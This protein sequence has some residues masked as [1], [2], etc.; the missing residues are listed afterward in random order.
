M[1]DKRT[2]TIHAR[3]ARRK[4]RS[5]ATGT[6]ERQRL[7]IYRSSKH[8]YAQVIDD[9]AGKTLVSVSS[10]QLAK[11]GTKSDM[12]VAVGKK[13]AELALQAGIREVV[14]DRAGYRYHGRI[15]ALAEAAREAG[16]K[17]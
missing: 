4:A 15:K 9:V 16:L 1:S 7:S 5:Q 12:S 3:R 8:I 14:F 11:A 2:P 17:F 13:C 6:R 10:E